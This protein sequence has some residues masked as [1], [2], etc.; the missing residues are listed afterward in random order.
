MGVALNKR[1]YSVIDA[2][3]P[4]EEMLKFAKEK[5]VYRNAMSGMLSVTKPMDIKDDTYDGAI[6]I[7]EEITK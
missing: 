6:C 5:Q 1:G 4:C 2:V 3:E 7:G